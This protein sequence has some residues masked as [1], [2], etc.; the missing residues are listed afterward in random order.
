MKRKTKKRKP[1][2]LVPDPARIAALGPSLTIPDAAFYVGV[3]IRRIR[4]WISAGEIGF[5][6]VGKRLLVCRA[7]LEKYIAANWQR[8]GTA[9]VNNALAS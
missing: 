3:P 1:A 4:D 7:D 8:N 2:R 9:T 5:Q 6:R